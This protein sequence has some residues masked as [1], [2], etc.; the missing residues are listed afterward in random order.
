MKTLIDG[1]QVDDSSEEWR[2]DCEARYIVS[3]PMSKR[4]GVVDLIGQRRG[5]EAKRELENMVYRAWIDKQVRMVL[6]MERDDQRV[7]RLLQ[8]EHGGNKRFRDAV[9]LE[10]NRRLAAGR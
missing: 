1:R 2:A 4:A 5:P 3:L 10:M 7:A 6:A 9:E 8:L